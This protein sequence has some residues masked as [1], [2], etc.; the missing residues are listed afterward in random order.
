MTER[1]E[2][3]LLDRKN[4]VKRE[5]GTCKSGTLEYSI[6][7]S[8]T[9]SGELE[10]NDFKNEDIDW[11]H[12]RIGI[13]FYKDGVKYPKGHWLMSVPEWQ[14]DESIKKATISLTDKCAL[15]DSSVGKWLTY[16]KG[17]NVIN[18]VIGIIKSKGETLIKA[19]ASTKTLSKAKTYAPDATWLEVVNDL[20]N[21]IGYD[22]LWVDDFGVFRLEDYVPPGER[23]IKG[24]YGAGGDYKMKRQFIDIADLTDIPT[25]FV[26]FTQG[27]EEVAG[28]IARVDLLAKHPLSASSRGYELLQSEQVEAADL[29]ALKKI[30]QSRLNDKLQITRKAEYTHPMDD[31]ELNDVVYN[32]HLLFKGPVVQ[33][34]ISLAAGAVVKDTMRWIYT[35]GELPWLTS[36]K[37]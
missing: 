1:W 19:T 15:F 33:R 9:G 32:N 14:Y 24:R 10:Y 7:R 27:D 30:A 18:T 25:G 20:L 31:V 13:N 8:V 5:L 4:Y 21:T 17:A 11:L 28:L 22:S 26:A 6:F 2:I 37:A 16:N 35:E 12:D 34:S 29:D 3:N 36:K 23:P